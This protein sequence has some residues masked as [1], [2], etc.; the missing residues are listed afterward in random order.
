MNKQTDCQSHLYLFLLSLQ[1]SF[2]ICNKNQL[3]IQRNDSNITGPPPQSLFRRIRKCLPL[4]RWC[5]KCCESD[6]AA[7]NGDSADASETQTVIGLSADRTDG[8]DGTQVVIDPTDGRTAHP[9]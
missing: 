3:R 6:A 4:P 1:F 2:D 9:L 5:C 8:T 7:G